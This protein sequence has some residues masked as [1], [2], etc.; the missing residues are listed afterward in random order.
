MIALSLLA[1]LCG[2]VLAFR[3][4]VFVLYPVIAAACVGIL[5]VGLERGTHGGSMAWQMVCAAIAL[6]A[7]YGFGIVSRSMIAAT[8]AHALRQRAA[9]RVQ[10]V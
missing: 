7:G 8:R 1:I 4:R 3:Y 9:S 10:P 5:A 2:A 6:Q